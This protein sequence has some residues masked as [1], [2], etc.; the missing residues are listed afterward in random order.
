MD[1]T[2][3]LALAVALVV[4][5]GA[6][7][8]LATRPRSPAAEA[9]GDSRFVASTEGMKMCPKCAMGNL[10]TERSCIA[11]GTKLKG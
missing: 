7:G 8:R 4:A 3:L 5:L 10:W 6:L 9:A 11:C 1:Q 2:F